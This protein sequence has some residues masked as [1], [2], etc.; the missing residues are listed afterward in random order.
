MDTNVYRKAGFRFRTQPLVALA[1]IKAWSLAHLVPEVWRRELEA[2]TKD[3]AEGKLNEARHA[4]QIGDWAMPAQAGAA[5]E[6]RQHLSNDTGEA[7]ATRLLKDHYSRS[8]AV[9]LP[10]A[11]EAGPQV[12]SAYFESRFPFERTGDKKSE[13]PDAFALA[14]LE[15]WARTKNRQVIVVTEDEGCL[16]ACDASSN[17]LG[18]KTLIEVLRGLSDINQSTQVAAEE[19]ENF[20]VR[21]LRSEVS[22]L[23]KDLDER[24]GS[25]VEQMDIDL[26]AD[27]EVPHFDYDVDEVS[28]RSVI[29]ASTLRPPDIKVLSVGQHELTF[30]WQFQVEVDVS[31]RFYRV[32]GHHLPQPH[33]YGAPLDT[34]AITIDV[35]AVITLQTVDVMSA[36]ALKNAS[37]R[38]VDFT[39]S[40]LWLYFGDVDPWEPAYEE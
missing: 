24:I 8:R 17:L 33:R 39:T 20:L 35:D 9:H 26:D 25:A 38:S 18:F 40:S 4:L 34:R 29:P 2:H 16:S 5:A 37:V 13:F 22:H 7:I 31:A 32:T 1:D 27:S 12:L 23:R 28:L 21:E 15:Q 36:V 3:W 10:T 19:L 6:L 30:S 11:W 14:T